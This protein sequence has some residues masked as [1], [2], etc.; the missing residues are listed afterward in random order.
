MKEEVSV[1]AQQQI[2]ELKE[3]VKS[4]EQDR[5]CAQKLNS[6]YLHRIDKLKSKLENSEK[7]I[8]DSKLF[9]EIES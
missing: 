8:F 2:E 1:T 4:L 7:T 3:Q 9:K 6:Q 5:D